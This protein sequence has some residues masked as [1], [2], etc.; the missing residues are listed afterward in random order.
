MRH[1]ATN[2]SNDSRLHHLF[3]PTI[4]KDSADTK[5]Y[6]SKEWNGRDMM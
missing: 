6:L 4:S 5:Q 3:A 2:A 1:A